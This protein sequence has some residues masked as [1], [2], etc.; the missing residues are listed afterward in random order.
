[1]VVRPFFFVVTREK[2]GFL[3][4]LFGRRK[5][6]TPDLYSNR[7]LH[8]ETNNFMPHAVSRHKNF[9]GKLI[10]HQTGELFTQGR[11]I[12]PK[13][14][15]AGQINEVGKIVLEE[16]QNFKTGRKTKITSVQDAGGS[17]RIIVRINKFGVGDVGAFVRYGQVCSVFPED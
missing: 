7:A 6:R 15:S 13:H 17:V 10:Y 8:P 9:G 1:M 4:S 11:G 14:M 3:Q 12:F 16:W 5:S 2:R